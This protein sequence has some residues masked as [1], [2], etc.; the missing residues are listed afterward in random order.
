MIKEIVNKLWTPSANQIETANLTKYTRWLRKEYGLQFNDYREL[1][2]WSVDHIEEFWEGLFI[3]FNVQYNG[4]LSSVKTDQ[5]MPHTNWFGGIQLN[6]T[7]HI[8]RN[9]QIDQPAIVSQN[10]QGEKSTLTWNALEEKAASLQIGRCVVKY[11]FVQH[12]LLLSSSLYCIVPI[13]YLH[14][15]KPF[16]LLV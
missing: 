8:F 4:E 7:E 16:S 15:E 3:Y 1:W 2:K 6:Y 12:H 9:K 11:C 14:V 5:P 13:V 10:E